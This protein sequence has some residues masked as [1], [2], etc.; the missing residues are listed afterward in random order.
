MARKSNRAVRSKAANHKKYTKIRGIEKRLGFL[1][2]EL[3]NKG[4]A[5]K[6]FRR[7]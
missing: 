6:G 1:L 5:V 2:R 3:K 4:V 7:S